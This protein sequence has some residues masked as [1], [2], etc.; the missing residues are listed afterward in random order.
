MQPQRNEP[1]ECGSGKKYKACCASRPA[2]R[3]RIALIALVLFA[4]AG[5]WVIAGAIRRV[6][7]D[8]PAEA[9]AAGDAGPAPPGKVWSAEHGHWHD[10]PAPGP[11]PDG[12]APPGK[13]W[14]AEHGH[15]HDAP[16]PVEAAPVAGESLPEEAVSRVEEP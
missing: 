8:E 16:A 12:E 14:S 11:A 1:C 4:V 2:P 7:S 5:L 9:A 13:V 3:Q 10:A 15:W 6:G